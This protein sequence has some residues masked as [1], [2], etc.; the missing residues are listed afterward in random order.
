MKREQ[1]QATLGREARAH[2]VKERRVPRVRA[3][4]GS[5]LG[6]VASALE[7][8]QLLGGGILAGMVDDAQ[9]LAELPSELACLRPER[10]AMLSFQR[11][12]EVVALGPARQECAL[13]VREAERATS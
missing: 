2:L 12:L 6:E 3:Q 10:M 4:H 8:D 13:L 9:A 5:A 1:L 11:P 7:V